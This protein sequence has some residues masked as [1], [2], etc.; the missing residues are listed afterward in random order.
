MVCIKDQYKSGRCGKG[1]FL[2]YRTAEM[3]LPPPSISTFQMEVLVLCDTLQRWFAPYLTQCSFFKAS[4]NSSLLG[5]LI[6]RIMCSLIVS[7]FVP[8]E[9]GRYLP[10]RWGQTSTC[11][12]VLFLSLL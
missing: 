8:H 4:I 9:F 6:L 7:S 11:E 3:M 10:V 12:P 2:C 5:K 1:D